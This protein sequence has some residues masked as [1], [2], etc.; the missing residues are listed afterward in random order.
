MMSSARAAASSLVMGAPFCGMHVEE[1]AF[2]MDCGLP[3]IPLY[4]GATHG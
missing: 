4:Q 2:S 1:L 3:T